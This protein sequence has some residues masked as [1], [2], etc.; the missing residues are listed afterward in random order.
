M[1]QPNV[2]LTERQSYHEAKIDGHVSVAT[3]KGIK[4]GVSLSYD[5]WC[6]PSTTETRQWGSIDTS[7]YQASLSKN[8]VGGYIL[9]NQA[10]SLDNQQV[11]AMMAMLQY[12]DNDAFRLIVDDL[13][14]ERING[15]FRDQTLGLVATG[16]AIRPNGSYFA[17]WTNAIEARQ[18]FH[19][20][21]RESEKRQA[22]GSAARRALQRSEP[23]YGVKPRVKNNLGMFMNKTGDDYSTVSDVEVGNVAVHHDTGAIM[24]VNFETGRPIV[25]GITSTAPSVRLAKESNQLIGDIGAEMVGI[26]GGLSRGR[27]GEFVVRRLAR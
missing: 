9:G 24:P 7:V 27:L 18:V 4:M 23:R 20:M 15:W 10:I 3:A 22:L 11:E 16:L 19:Y 13:G 14:A 5:N 1:K 21:L 6:G 26:A 2:S 25:Y 17:G 12:S 8:L